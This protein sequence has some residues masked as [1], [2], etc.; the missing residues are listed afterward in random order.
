MNRRQFLT[1]ATASLLAPRKS[2]AA[3]RPPNILLILAD[4]LGYGDLGCYGQ[5]RIRTPFL[6]QMA[7]EGVRFT[8]A[9]AGS[10]ICAPS[11]C[12]LETGLHTGHTVI[13]GNGEQFQ[14]LRP[15][16]VTV[17][18]LLKRAGYRTGLIGKWSLGG[19][20]TTGYPLRQG[21]DEW[22][23]YFSQT[24]AHNYYP[25]MLL[26]NDHEFLVRGNFGA[27]KT[28][29]SHDLFTQRALEFLDR[30]DE[31]P[32][33]LLLAYTIPHANNELGRDTGNGMEVPDF[34]PYATTDWPEPEKGFAAM[35]TRLDADVGKILDYLK[36]SGKA[37]NTLVLF[38]SDN[39][40]HQE[41]GHS[42]EFFDSNGSLRGF[43]RDLYEGGI[44]V[45]AIAWWPG[46]IRAGR[47]SHHPWAFWDFLP[48]CC[49]LA[50]IPV[51][52]GIDGISI[53]PELLE[54]HQP[55]H[56]YLYWEVAL[57]K[58]VLRAIRWGSW[59]AIQQ[60]GSDRLELYNLETSPAEDR[61]VAGEHPDIASLLRRMM[62]AAHE[63]WIEY[64]ASPQGQ[65][66][67]S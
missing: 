42:A 19:L 44:R 61:D 28:E 39:G 47:I 8:Q 50:G 48:T 21:Y 67:A 20:G 62:D 18:K 14:P 49:E 45:P 51:P 4:D 57:S 1:I 56:E 2:R 22:F 25:E 34:G 30:R 12:S 33:F 16:E 13:R 38:T 41:G 54:R 53:V 55:R 37:E 63:D 10:T 66:G 46:Q 35:I 36:T 26:E 5:K 43:K 15:Q 59:K 3:R 23:G 40:P 17:A 9:Y 6:D 52:T 64:P 58:R 11:R 24:H 7:A 29:Y 27:S 60:V 31:R 32:F 65:H